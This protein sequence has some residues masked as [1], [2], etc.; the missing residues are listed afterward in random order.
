MIERVGVAQ[1]WR[2]IMIDGKV[3]VDNIYIYTLITMSA[4][5]QRRHESVREYSSVG[6][7]VG[8]VNGRGEG[9]KSVIF[10]RVVLTI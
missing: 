10:R 7:G 5:R 6:V 9:Q 8:G 1:R 2:K 3:C 4:I